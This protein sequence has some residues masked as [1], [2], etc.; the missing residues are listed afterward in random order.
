LGINL[1]AK[2]GLLHLLNHIMDALDSKCELYWKSIIKLGNAIYIYFVEHAEAAVLKALKD[3][4]FSK[5][6][7]TLSNTGIRDLCHNKRWKQR[8]SKLLRKLILPGATQRYCLNLW[9][10]EFKNDKDQSGR[11][12][13]TQNT[14]KVAT[15]Q[16]K[17]VHHASDVPGMDMY[18]AILPDLRSTHGVLKWKCDRPKSPLEKFHELLA[19][20]GNSGMNKG[21]SDTLTLGGT[22]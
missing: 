9:I 13:F 15:E 4:S 6:G 16:L 11:P 17:K 18:Q 7:E 14:K 10:E 19:H 3:G 20:F 2:L 22:T 1:E 21:Q 5:T 12:V 8:Y